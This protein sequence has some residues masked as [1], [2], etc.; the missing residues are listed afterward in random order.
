MMKSYEAYGKTV[1]EAIDAACAM[2]G[3]S[4]DSVEIEIL[5]L[6]GKGIFGLGRKDA[7][8]RITL[9]E[10]E[11][12][13]AEAPRQKAGFGPKKAKKQPS[14]EKKEKQEIEIKPIP[15]IKPGAPLEPEKLEPKAADKEQQ[16][17]KSRSKSNDRGRRNERRREDRPQQEAR[18]RESSAAEITEGAMAD[19]IFAAAKEYITPVF[20]C[21]GIDPEY[22]YHVKEGVLWIILSGQRLGLLIGR[23]GDT[24]NSL[25][26][27]VNLAVNRH[28]SDHVR[29]VLDVEGYR[30]SREQTLN[31]LAKKM[32]EKAVRTGRRVELE[33]MNPHERRIVHMALQDD[34]R[35]DTS[36]RGQEPYRRVVVTSRRRRNR[37]GGQRRE[38]VGEPLPNVIIEHE[39]E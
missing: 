12:A 8:V 1:D 35:V 33:P 22:S 28:R 11:E 26:Y 2:A 36:S 14:R 39:E 9:E 31:A 10:K 24:L 21:M 15:V 13:P 4:I 18:I 3:V 19:E 38:K 7:K 27:L 20:T 16:G 25:Q 23:R 17:E 6:G 34:N 32:A 30:D 5:E 37:R 29:L